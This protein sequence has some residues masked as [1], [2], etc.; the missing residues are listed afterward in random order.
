LTFPSGRTRS[1]V[2]IAVI[3]AAYVDGLIPALAR[4][5]SPSIALAG[6]LAIGGV[7]ALAA[8]LRRAGVDADTTM[9]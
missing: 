5:E 6:A 7:L 2:A 4:D 1:P 9:L 3:A 8:V